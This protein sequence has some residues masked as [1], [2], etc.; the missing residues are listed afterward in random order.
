MITAVDSS[1]LLDL[2]VP[3]SKFAEWSERTL[4]IA[5]QD[6][7][8][9][10]SEC[11][12][13]EIRPAFSEDQFDSFLLDLR[14]QFVPSTL[15]SARLAGEYFKQYLDRGGAANRIIADFIIG[16]HALTHA[17]RL[18]ARDRGYLRDYFRGLRLLQPE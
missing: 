6:G 5:Q 7:G 11:V 2:V 14:L 4:R 18:L 3:N 10:I 12:V 9:I 15:E 8:L 1:V 13:A 16:A 17:D